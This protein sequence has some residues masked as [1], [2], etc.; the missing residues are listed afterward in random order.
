M[1]VKLICRPRQVVSPEEFLADND[2]YPEFSIGIDGAVSGPPF[3]RADLRKIVF[4]HHEGVNRMFTRS[5]CDQAG[6]AIKLG[7][8][9]SFRCRG[10][11]TAILHLIDADQDA[12]LTAYELMHP[13]TAHQLK[14]VQLVRTEDLQDMSAGLFPVKRRQPLMRRLAWI[15]Q[16]Y[17][18]MKASGTY[19]KIDA[20]GMQDLI[21]R[22]H[23]R[24]AETLEGRGQEVSLD[25]EFRLIEQRN[26]WSLVEEIG[27][28]ARVGLSDADIDAFVSVAGG[29]GGVWRYKIIRR[30]ELIPF[31]NPEIYEALNDAEGLGSGSSDR[32][33]GSLTSGGSPQDAGSRLDPQGVASV[34]DRVL[35]PPAPFRRGGK[36]EVRH[37]PR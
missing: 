6:V 32:W 24:I 19:D 20:D 7:L 12:S 3:V 10:R 8:Y 22:I 25:T 17:T 11:P 21:S 34:I 26:G 2:E 13:E 18:E 5:C 23:Q 9:R 14:M 29:E 35:T 27:E 36:S 1:A 15:N 30:S 4:N 28:H 33:G 37:K 16:P 31:P